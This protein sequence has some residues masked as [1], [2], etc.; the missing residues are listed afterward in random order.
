MTPREGL[1]WA[2]AFIDQAALDSELAES[3][4]ETVRGKSL[5]THLR[6]RP[7]LYYPAIYAYCQQAAEKTLKALL[8]YEVGSIPRKHNALGR[9][10]RL[11][12]MKERN[13][14]THPELI[15]RNRESINHI[16]DMAPGASS[17]TTRLED[18][19][20]QAN[21]EY[22]FRASNGAI[23]LP[24]QEISESDVAAALK[25]GRPL[26]LL[27]RKYLEVAGLAPSYI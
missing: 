24:C 3:L 9:V 19:L 15:Y 27:T 18:L 5:G 11:K 13:R 22:P 10:L 12:Q 16:L 4:Y 26:V 14:S 1:Q 17:A 8:W 20:N 23:L 25:I 2:R 7:D 21:T 6:S